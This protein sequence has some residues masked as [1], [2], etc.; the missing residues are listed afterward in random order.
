VDIEGCSARFDF[1]LMLDT[2]DLDGG[3][4]TGMTALR[5]IVVSE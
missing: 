4:H 2:Q 3:R 1:H 5:R